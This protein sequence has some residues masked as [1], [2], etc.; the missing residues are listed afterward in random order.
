MGDKRTNDYA[1]ALRAVSTVA[2][3]TAESARLPYEVLE[4]VMNRIVHEVKGV[5]RV[6]YDLTSKPPGTIEFE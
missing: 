1:V 6:F 5:H 3:M 2:F 4:K